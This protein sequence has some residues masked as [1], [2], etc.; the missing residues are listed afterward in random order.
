MLLLLKNI[1]VAFVASIEKDFTT[2]VS[3]EKDTGVFIEKEELGTRQFFS[4]ATMTTRQR[5]NATT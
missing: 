1:N 2:E 4:F 5:D 3:T